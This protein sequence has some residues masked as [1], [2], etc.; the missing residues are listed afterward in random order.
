MTER[1]TIHLPVFRYR[2]QA[3]NPTCA[4]DFEIGDV[5]KFYRTQ[6]MGCGETCV[7]AETREGSRYAQSMD[8]R[9]G[10]QGPGMGTLIPG[11]W[12]PVWPQNDKAPG[13]STEG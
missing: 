3:G 1:H 4:A 5:C 13:L 11:A 7:F 6:R 12:C 10:V 2:D 8:R 9:D